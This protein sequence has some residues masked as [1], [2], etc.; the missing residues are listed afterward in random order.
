MGAISRFVESGGRRR[1]REQ[2]LETKDAYLGHLRAE[3][4]GR[5]AF[6]DAAR[7]IARGCRE[8]AMKFEYYV[9]AVPELSPK[10][11]EEIRAHAGTVN[12]AR[13][14]RWVSDCAQ[15]QKQKDERERAAAAE[16]RA[17]NTFELLLPGATGESL[18]ER[19]KNELAAG[20][21]RLSIENLQRVTQAVAERAQSGGP[22]DPG[23][24]GPEPA[25]EKDFDFGG[26]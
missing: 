7:E 5:E 25:K 15:S 9:Q 24:S 23:R 21:E 6:H 17:A 18:A 12:G 16:A 2:L 13:S 20:R 14:E 11:M 3:A 19:S 4:Q 1:L 22:D 10:T 26:R 8:L